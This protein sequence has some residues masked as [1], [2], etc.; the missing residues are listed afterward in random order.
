MGNLILTRKAGEKIIFTHQGVEIEVTFVEQH[1][2]GRIRLGIVAPPAVTVLRE[3]LRGKR[4][5]QR[6]TKTA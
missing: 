6:N 5:E 3:E 2:H 1:S 4:R